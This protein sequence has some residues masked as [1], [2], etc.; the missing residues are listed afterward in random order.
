MGLALSFAGAFFLTQGLK[1][2]IGKPRPDFLARCAPDLAKYDSSIVSGYGLS[3]EEAYAFVTASV[4]S[5]PNKSVLDDGFASFPSGHSSISW[6]G[7]LYLSLWLSSKLSVAV[8][9]LSKHHLRRNVRTTGGESTSTGEAAPPMWLLVII[10]VPVGVAFYISSTRYSDYHHSG[11]D[12]IV[13]SLIGA[14]FAW[15]AFR[16]YHQ[17]IRAGGG[18]A[19]GPRNRNRAFFTGVGVPS[20]ADSG[21]GGGGHSAAQSGARDLE[22]QH[23]SGEG[24]LNSPQPNPVSYELQNL[25]HG[26]DQSSS[27]Y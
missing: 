22:S 12:I 17:P 15:F 2:L 18:W 25:A 9:S 4:C 3:R 16:W 6:S 1:D 23:G 8:P 20:Y 7:L 27:Q 13:G 5:Q 11:F 26:R 10:S 19:W 24:I 14:F 21:V